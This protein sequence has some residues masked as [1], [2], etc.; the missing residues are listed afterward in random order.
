MDEFPKLETFFDRLKYLIETHSGG[1]HTVF[2]RF[3]GIPVSTFQN[4]IN[5]QLPKV[6]HVI[7]ISEKC[8]ISI[9]WLLTGK[10]RYLNNKGEQIGSQP[11][12]S[13][14]IELQHM[15]L[16]KGFKDKPRALNIN[17][18]LME[19]EQLD[20]DSLKRVESYIKG[21]VDTVREVNEKSGRFSEERRFVERRTTNDPGRTPN[22]QDRRS[23][24]DRR[25]A[26]LKSSAGAK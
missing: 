13:N 24:H 19:L 5:G 8:N 7:A 21:T 20:S 25:K 16:V 18:Y 17:H 12:I 14:A 1:R 3:V 23:C 4:I 22:G 11:N 2:A 15:E 10:D 6:E 9:D 26:G